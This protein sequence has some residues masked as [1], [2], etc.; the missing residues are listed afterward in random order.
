VKVK[1]ID[2]LSKAKNYAF[3]LLKFR[4]RSEKEIRVRLKK[5]KFDQ[6]IIEET[7]A[8]LKD[9]DFINDNYFAKAWVESRLK[10]PLGLRRIKEELKVKGIDKE[11]IDS[12]IG[13]IKKSY[14]EEDIVTEIARERFNRLKNIERELAKRRLYAYL[15]RRGF[16]PEIV[17]NVLN[18]SHTA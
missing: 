14:S 3:L 5:K 4:P 8:F 1:F 15:L 13:E 12:Q 10:R 6:E 17:I 2:L 16:S 11:I 7:V 18:Q 9:K